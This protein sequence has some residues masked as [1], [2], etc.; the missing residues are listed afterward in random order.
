MGITV[1]GQDPR[2]LLASRLAARGAR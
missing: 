1:D 2:T